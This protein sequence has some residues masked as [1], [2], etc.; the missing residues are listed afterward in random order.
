MIQE[1]E[2]NFYF[3]D[4]IYGVPNDDPGRLQRHRRVD[5]LTNLQFDANCETEPKIGV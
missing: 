4:R 3:E 5:P 1:F 2:R